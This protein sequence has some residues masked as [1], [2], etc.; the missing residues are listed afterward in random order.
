VLNFFSTCSLLAVRLRS[1]GSDVNDQDMVLFTLQDLGSDFETF[2]T[3]ISLR[4]QS[5]TI[6]ELHSLLLAHEARLLA[7]FRI[8]TSSQAVHLTTPAASSPFPPISANSSESLAIYAG[9]TSQKPFSS[10]STFT[11]QSDRG[12]SNYNYNRGRSFRGRDC[13]RN[14]SSDRPQC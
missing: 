14:V 10:V 2:V 5:L 8:T 13:G 7:N 4:H 6:Q 12:C 11:F 9:F 3:V 1:I